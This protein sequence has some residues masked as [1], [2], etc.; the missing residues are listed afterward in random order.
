VKKLEKTPTDRDDRP[1][2]PA[3]MNK[4]TILEG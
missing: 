2:T 1:L 4:V 3:R